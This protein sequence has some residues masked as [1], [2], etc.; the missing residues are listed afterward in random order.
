MSPDT[1]LAGRLSPSPNFGRRAEGRAI[2]TLLL[3]YTD[4]PT[5]EGAIAW[6]CDPRSQVSCH[7]VVAEDGAVTQLVAEADRAWHAGAG[8]WKGQGDVNS[9]SIGIEIANLG[10]DH[11]YPDFPPV[12]IEAVIALACDIC[13]RNA[14]RPERVLAHSDIA[15]ERKRDPGEKFPWDR[16]HAAG[17]GHFVPPEPIRGGRFFHRGDHGAPVEALQGLLAW[18]G[19]ELGIDGIFGTRTEA[20]VAA[21]QRHFR[22]ERV[23]GIADASTIATLH[24]LARAIT[25]PSGGEGV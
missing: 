1:P 16:L 5:A 7:Y 20:V 8:S 6:L 2:D 15:P 25:P 12:Q 17:V 10:H 14:I 13:A 9:G 19:Y 3:H 22:P 21:F 18:Y 23:D 11:G 24:R 4:M